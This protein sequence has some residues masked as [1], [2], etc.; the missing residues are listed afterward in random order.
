VLFEAKTAKELKNIG[1]TF[2]SASG[3]FFSS[4]QKH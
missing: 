1:S 2:F 4:E 3:K